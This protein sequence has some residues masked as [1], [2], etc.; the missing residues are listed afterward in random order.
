M[1][2]IFCIF[3]LFAF[4][5]AGNLRSEYDIHYG[6]AASELG[7][8][9]IFGF[10]ATVYPLK[11][12]KSIGFSTGIEY[13]SKE[14]KISHALLEETQNLI[15]NEDEE[16]IFTSRFRDFEERLSASVLQIPILAKYTGELSYA[17][18]GLKIG[19]PLTLEAKINYSELATEGY[20]PETNHTLS[21]LPFQ[22]FGTYKGEPIEA[23]FTSDVLFTLAVEYGAR[24]EFLDKYAVMMGIFVEHALN[25]GFSKEKS[26][27]VERTY[28][29][30]DAVF[31]VNYSWNSWR[32]WSAGVQ[33]KFAFGK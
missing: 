11:T 23:K 8:K 20:F 32:P 19:I 27:R 24:F 25:N 12:S 30:D 1:K 6:F 22:G 33:L 18:A 2:T 7:L 5:F 14:K 29:E 31:K 28:D 4:S 15:D 9:N 26:P 17:S 21:D 13:S 16:F 3:V 10:T